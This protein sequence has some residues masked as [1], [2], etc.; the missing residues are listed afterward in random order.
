MANLIVT[1]IA[2]A[3]VA[4]ASLMGAY[5]GGQA[6]LKGSVKANANSYINQGSQIAGAFALFVNEANGQ[7]PNDIAT[8]VT[9]G[10][11]N[12]NMTSPTGDLY[13]IGVSG[14]GSSA[15]YSAHVSGVKSEVCAQIAEM[16]KNGSTLANSIASDVP[17]DGFRYACS[18]TEFAYRLQ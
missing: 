18:G 6:F 1:V 14:S 3:L 11:L 13:S 10:Y 12:D 17:A 15:K 8:L 4:I 9:S 16:G 5:Y 7:V 2:I